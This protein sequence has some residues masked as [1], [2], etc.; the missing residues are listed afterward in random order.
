MKIS[1]II[2]VF[3]TFMFLACSDGETASE[4]TDHDDAT[5]DNSTQ[6]DVNDENDSEVFMDNDNEST[7][8]EWEKE[9]KS[10]IYDYE[11][12]GIFVATDGNDTSGNGSLVNPYRTI[13][14]ALSYAPAGSTIILRSGT[15]SEAVRIRQSNIT[16]R[17][18]SNEFAK[19]ETP[20]DN[21]DVSATVIL[22]VDSD[23]AK[24]QRLEIVGGYYYGV[25]LWTRWDWGESDR[26]GTSNITIEDCKIHDTGRDAI[27]VT[28]GCDF[29]TIRRN[30]IYNSGV[31]DDGNAEG[32]DNVNGDFM[33]VQENYIHNTATN[34]VYCKG[35]AYGCV[36]ERNLLENCGSAG[37][38]VGFDTS[39]EFFDLEVNPDRYENIRG[40]VR[41]NIIVNTG[42]AGIGMYAAKD[43]VIVNNTLLNTAENNHS[44]IYFGV[45]LQDWEHDSDP[46]DGIGYRPG[47]INPV[48]MNNIVVQ[49]SS[50]GGATIFIRSFYDDELGRIDALEGDAFFGGNIYYH[51]SGS[52]L[53]EDRR[54]E[55]EASG[56]LEAWKL[57]SDTDK[58]S[59]ETDPL[60]G[61]DYHLMDG[62]PA[63]DKGLDSSYISLDFDGEERSGKIDIGADEVM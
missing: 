9:K 6:Q 40:I 5:T 55:S 34:C 22:D 15:Y 27:K 36:I 10:E 26:T 54:P 45:T 16:I 49:P 19:I 43:S 7:L 61:A 38:M 13:S 18:M 8:E 12:E 37:V 4:S 51:E 39:P 62:S 14:H 29:V 21:S 63:V 28:P 32:I 24:L 41:N 42:L 23:G 1:L 56:D 44:P 2:S 25:M 30:E 58:D 57:H 17:S 48:V 50:Y 20:T 3:V 31:R 52:F 60:L 11:D 59:L 35:G 46:D 47:S 53:F 33:L